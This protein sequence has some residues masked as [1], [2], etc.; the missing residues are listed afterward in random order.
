MAALK[1]GDRN[2]LLKRSRDSQVTHDAALQS[3]MLAVVEAG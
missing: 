3:A 2:P 1:F